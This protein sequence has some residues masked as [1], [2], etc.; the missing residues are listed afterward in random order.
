M[1]LINT[2]HINSRAILLYVL[3]RTIV[4]CDYIALKLFFLAEEYESEGRL[5]GE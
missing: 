4:A 5:D 1:S 3:H 2:I